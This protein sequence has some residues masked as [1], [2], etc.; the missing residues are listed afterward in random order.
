MI[1]IG[2]KRGL[3]MSFDIWC[4]FMS[5]SDWFQEH[6]YTHIGNGWTLA[7]AW[8]NTVNATIGGVGMLIGPQA[9]KSLNSIEKIRPR[10]MVATFNS[11][12]SATIICS[13]LPMLGKKLNSLPS[14]MSYPLLLIASWNT[15]FSSLAET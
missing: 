4:H 11:N 1:E 12:P 3:D 14:M 15:T 2:R 10:M 13:A 8:K 7:S 9:L 5:A 6:T